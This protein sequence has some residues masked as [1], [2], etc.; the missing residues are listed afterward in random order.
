MSM[1]RY[2]NINI[3]LISDTDRRRSA[4]RLLTKLTRDHWMISSVQFDRY[5]NLSKTELFTSKIIRA[6]GVRC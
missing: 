2:Q 1:T 4:A 6:N 3:F 5:T